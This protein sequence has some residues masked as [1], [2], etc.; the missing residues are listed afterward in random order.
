MRQ[1]P[2]LRG[3]KAI[4]FSAVLSGSAWRFTAGVAPT[5][6]EQSSTTFHLRH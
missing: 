1:S 3:V 2:P 6:T 5:K 4:L